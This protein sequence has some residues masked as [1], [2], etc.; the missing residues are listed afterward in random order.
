VF[1]AVICGFLLFP[2]ALAQPQQQ[3]P[4]IG[5]WHLSI[6]ESTFAARPQYK[7][8]ITKIESRQDGLKVVYDM[9]GVRGGVTH[10]EWT[11]RVDGRDYALQGVEEVVTNAY[12]RI[13][14]RQYTITTKVDG[15]VT[16]AATI[17][18]SPDGRAMTVK[19]SSNRAIYYK[20]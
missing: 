17:D 1:R 2:A 16:T 12:A 11:G 18:I 3:E 14:D 9:V 8:V 20:Q 10:W 7:R 13:A 6:D 15:R 4:L 5:E 19:D